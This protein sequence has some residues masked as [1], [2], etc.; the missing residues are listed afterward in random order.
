M[1]AGGSPACSTA[2]SRRSCVWDPLT[3]SWVGNECVCVMPYSC[4]LRKRAG[5]RPGE[6]SGGQAS[7][8]DCSLSCEWLVCV[9]LPD[10]ELSGE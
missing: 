1:K 4:L 10:Q 6:E 7:M 8:L 2:R 5:A 3:R 9:A